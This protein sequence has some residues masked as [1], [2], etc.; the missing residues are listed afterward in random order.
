MSVSVE[1]LAVL[2]Y[3]TTHLEATYALVTVDTHLMLTIIR[4][5]VRVIAEFQSFIFGIV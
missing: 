2:N 4:A 1:L 3:A 5:M